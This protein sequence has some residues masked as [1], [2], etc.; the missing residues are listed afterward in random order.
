MLLQFAF[1]TQQPV[2]VWK[3]VVE[4]HPTREGQAGGGGFRTVVDGRSTAQPSMG[5]RLEELMINYISVGADAQIIYQ[6][7]KHRQTSQLLNKMMMVVQ[8]SKHYVPFAKNKPP[9]VAD[10]LTKVQ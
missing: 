9:P 8:T 3:V 6:F 1:A 2:D 10:F 7:E 4:T 5:T